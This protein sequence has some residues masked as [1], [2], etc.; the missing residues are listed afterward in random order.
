MK[1]SI[2]A[3]LIACAIGSQLAARPVL[4]DQSAPSPTP[5]PTPTTAAAKVLDTIVTTAERRTTTIRAASRE[6]YVVTADDLAKFVS[7]TLAQALSF[8]PGL[9]VKRNGAFGGVESLLARGASSEQTLVLIDGRPAGDADLGDFD[10][11]SLAPDGVERIEVV[12]GGASTLYGSGAVGGVINIITKGSAGTPSGSAYQQIGFEG[13]SATGFSASGGTPSVLATSLTVRSSHARDQFDY[14]GFLTIPAGTRTDDDA[15][16]QDVT[17]SLGRD[18]GIVHGTLRLND[19]TNDVGAPGDLEFCAAPP[20]NAFCP[21]GLARQLRDWGR[22]EADFEWQDGHNDVTIQG[23][24]DGRRLHFY[25]P[26]PSFPFDTLTTLA[27]RGASVRDVINAGKS[28]TVVAGFDTRGDTAMFGASFYLAPTIASDATTAWYVEDDTH[29]Q[30]SPVG[31]SFGLRR[32]HPQGVAAVTV[33]SLGITDTLPNGG[34]VRANYAR[35]FRSPTLDERYFPN[36]GTP[37]LQ[38]EYGATYDV[39][40]SEPLRRALA[41]LTYFGTDTNN[42][43]IDVPI[44]NFGDVAPENVASARVRGFDASLRDPFG[45]G[46]AATASYTDY[47]EARDLTMGTRL[48]YRPTATAGVRLERDV[49]RTAYGLDLDYVGQRY[50]DEKNTVLLPPFA[51]L[52]GFGR[53]TIGAGSSLMLRVDNLTG[54]RV[55]ESYGY[56]VMGPTMSLTFS[57]AWR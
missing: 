34:A 27:T 12:E 7:P 13:A 30:R 57:Q 54:E 32:E 14:P 26:A 24:S 21:S 29:A 20:N 2:V 38:P 48:L 52:G 19:D 3:A 6:T 55:E 33:P 8:V 15:K 17:L 41:S 35:S 18:F 11:S 46:F 39:G 49:A 45:A 44:D 5:S 36:F 23:Y 10:L 31:L 53:V 42:L 22:S 43:I 51:S 37:T 40:V 16:A 56:P 9:F 1:F 47:P 50:A 28:N 4:A 25:D